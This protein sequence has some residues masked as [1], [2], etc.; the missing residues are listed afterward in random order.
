M[1]F[2]PIVE[3]KPDDELM[4]MVY[5]FDQWD[6]A[7]LQAVENELAK[8]KIL[9]LDVQERKEALISN[10]ASLMGEAK[11]ASNVGIIVG[12]LTCLGLLGI[13]I[14]Y[15]YAFS[16][17]RSKYGT[18]VYFE[19]NQQSRNNGKALFYTSL[20]LISLEIIYSLL[21]NNGVAV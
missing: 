19:Y 18:K 3:A 16:K 6:P 12:W 14:G 8:R 17:T 1:D 10:E 11:Q 7:M 5:E 9:P 4:Q 21:R 2:N 13:F 20:T 15:H